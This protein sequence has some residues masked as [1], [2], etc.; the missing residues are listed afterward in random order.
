VFEVPFVRSVAKGLIP[1]HA[2]AA[3]AHD[4]ASA[5]SIR[6][7]IAVNDLEISFNSQRTIAIDSDLGS[8]HLLAILGRNICR[9]YGT[10][11]IFI[12]LMVE[13]V[14]I[15]SAFLKLMVV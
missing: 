6:I 13:L 8:G 1:G 9:E 2:T 5:Q 3:D 15:F 12:E 10:I 7:P 11:S 4:L 14:E